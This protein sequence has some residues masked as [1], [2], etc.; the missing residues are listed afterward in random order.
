MEENCLVFRNVVGRRSGFGVERR[1]MEM[2]FQ[3]VE[4][5]LAK[6]NIAEDQRPMLA[7]WLTVSI[8][9]L[10][11]CWVDTTDAP[12]MAVLEQF[13]LSSSLLKISK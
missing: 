6:Q 8:V 10:M 5:D 1:F 12:A 3:L 13:M 4:Q 2:V 9:G 11:A 7:R